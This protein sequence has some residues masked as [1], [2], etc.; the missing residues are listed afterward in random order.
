M[1]WSLEQ[2]KYL[3]DHY[4]KKDTI[5]IAKELRKSL[6]TVYTKAQRMGLKYITQAERYAMEQE[7]KAKM[8]DTKELIDN[9]LLRLGI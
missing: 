1:R 5:Y 7:R 6:P 9:T 4:G 3:I 8:D 2:E